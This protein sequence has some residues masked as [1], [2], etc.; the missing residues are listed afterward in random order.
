MENEGN[1][2]LDKLFF[3]AKSYYWGKDKEHLGTI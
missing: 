3:K 1:F 2:G